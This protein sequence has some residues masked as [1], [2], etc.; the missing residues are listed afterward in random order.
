MSDAKGVRSLKCPG[1]NPTLRSVQR[2]AKA[3]GVDLKVE[4]ETMRTIAFF[5]HAGGVAK[6]SSVRDIDF[7]L[8]E[9]G[10]KVLLIDVDPQANLMGEWL[11]IQDPPALEETIFNAVISNGRK[12]NDLRLPHPLR[13]RNLDLIPSS[14]TW[15]V[16]IC[17]FRANST[18]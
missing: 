3:L 14:S 18:A 16:S 10:F 7:S 8:V 1:S 11:G 17:C 6:T 5:N 4:V 13:A 9:Q 2:Y 15:H 12:R